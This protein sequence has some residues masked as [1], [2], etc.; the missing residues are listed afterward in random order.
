MKYA[1]APE[2]FADVFV[3]PSKAADKCLKLASPLQMRALIWFCRNT[4][5]GDGTVAAG[6]KALGADEGE[7]ADALDYWAG[8]GILTAQPDGKISSPAAHEPEA[9]PAVRTETPASG[10]ERRPLPPKLTSAMIRAR[11][12]EDPTISTLLTESQTILGRTLGPADTN[13]LIA[14]HDYYGLPTEVI[15]LLCGFA[16]QKGKSNNMNY[17]YALG[18]EWSDAGIDDFTSADEYIRRT[19]ETDL[20]WENFCARI[21]ATLPAPSLNQLK[22]LRKWRYDRG[23]SLELICRAYDE[24]AGHVKN[25]SF[26]YMDKILEKWFN[27]GISSPEEADRAEQARK[28]AAAA[29]KRTGE[30]SGVD[31]DHPQPPS[32]DLTDVEKNARSEIPVFVKK[33]KRKRNI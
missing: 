2:M 10:P 27:N 19:E 30:E 4:G 21:G 9:E 23:F 17:I 11:I 14:L 16:V 25:F 8:E 15:M 31:P 7:F 13:V 1:I 20:F 24:M 12:A 5:L 18:R 6:A 26:A 22:Y 33:K 3:M 28:D 32:F 29:R